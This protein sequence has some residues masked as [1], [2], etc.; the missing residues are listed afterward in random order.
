MKLGTEADN[1]A[2]HHRKVHA[3][4]GNVGAWSYEDDAAKQPASRAAGTPTAGTTAEAAAAP[5]ATAATTAKAGPSKP[6][7]RS[8]RHAK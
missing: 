8:S 3:F 1:S 2:R 6:P 4:R 7:R 5:P